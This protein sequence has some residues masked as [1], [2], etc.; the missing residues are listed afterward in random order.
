MAGLTT[1]LNFARASLASVAGQTAVASR[2]V[3]NANDPAYARKSALLSQV[4]G[5][6][7]SIAGYGR[8]SDSL[9]LE[10]AL[11]ATSNSGA[12]SAL[13]DGLKRLSETIGDPESSTSPAGMLG[14]FQVALQLFERAPSDTSLG[15]NALKAAQDL[16]RSLNEATSA[17]Q[18]VRAEADGGMAR[19]VS[20]I[21]DLLRQFQSANDAIIRSTGETAEAAEQKDLR[22]KTLKLI[23]EEI[24]VR[25]VPQANG[26][27]VL[28]TDGGV[29]LFDTVPRVVSFQATTVMTAATPGNAVYIDG[30]DV[31]SAQSPMALR[32][33]TMFGLAKLRDE[34]AVTYQA[35][36]DEM[37]RG[38]IATFAEQD[39]SAAALPDATGLFTYPGAPAVP[40]SATLVSGLAGTIRINAAADPAQGGSIAAVRDG[41]M[42]GPAYIY[43]ASAASGF[44]GR[45][46]QLVNGLDQPQPFDAAA[47]LDASVSLTSYAAKSVGWLESYRQTASTSADIQSAVRARAEDALQRVTGVS[48]DD[49]MAEM[50]KLERSYQASSKLIAA[51]D[52]MF[53]SLLQ[54]A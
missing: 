28:Y 51:V 47:K 14:K 39:Q 16:A 9:L 43:N 34:A 22:D 32:A 30:V 35:Q 8:S 23:A 33:G 42:N 40:A 18:Q 27:L 21:N 29:T 25:A 50:L 48:I 13:L 2:N 1:A 5:G 7:V 36:L 44:Q 37:A 19:S 54:A 15:R 6:Y 46:T 17:V 49:E 31:T 10:K 53:Q 4:P 45:L 38:L 26:G 24:G 52:S 41:G 11:S 3:A 20:R 12:S